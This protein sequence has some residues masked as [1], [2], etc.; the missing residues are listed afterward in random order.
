MRKITPQNLAKIPFPLNDVVTKVVPAPTEG[1]D[2]ISP[3]ASMDPK[4]API[5]DNW[6]PRPGWIEL[7]AGFVP[8]AWIGSSTPVNTLMVYRAL[9]VER[10]FA[11]A[12]SHIFEVTNTGTTGTYTT[13]VSGLSDSHWQ[14]VNFTPPLAATVIQ[15]VNGIDRMQMFNGTSW[16]KEGTDFNITGL[17][18]GLTSAQIINISA[19][20]RRFWYVLTNGS[21]AGS[22]VCAYMPTDAIQGAI[23]GSIDLGALWTKGGYLVAI[24]DWTVD[25]GA[26]PQDYTVFLSSRGQVSIYAGT[27]PTNAAAW[28]LVATFDLSPPIS[29]RCMTRVGSDL[30]LI[31]L[32]GIIPLSTA[33]PF[34]PSADR[35]VAITARIQNAMADDALDASANFGWQFLT[36]P[37]ETLAF[38]NVPLVENVQQVQ[39]VMNT[40]TGAWCRFTGWNANCFE[41]FNDNL[42]LGGNDGTINWAYQ[43]SLDLNTSISASVQCAFNYFDDPGRLKRITMVQ[44]LLTASGNITPT[45]SIDEDFALS[46]QT[47]SISI[48][49]GGAQWDVGEWDVSL[50]A[51][52]SMTINPWLSVEAIGHALAVHMSVNVTPQTAILNQQIGEFDIGIFDSATFDSGISNLAPQLQ[53]NAFNTILE[54]GGFISLLLGILLSCGERLIT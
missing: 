15:C 47:A 23:A 18:A 8:W 31:T 35:S 37:S 13:P 29:R 9:G 27:D 11:A 1:W 36:Y 48:L 33:L 40:L 51:G 16:L 38:L 19:Q 44:P 45:I 17:P 12:G 52:G 21:G 26:G 53:I 10:L 3:L 22:T 24:G 50:W 25:G 14:Y 32:Q 30:G 6:V 54:L 2:A 42:Y 39:L 46:T 28:A 7:R 34:D 20:K 5:M 43:G 49:S 41:I 4:R